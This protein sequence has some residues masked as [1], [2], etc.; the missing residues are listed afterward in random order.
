[1]SRFTSLTA[2]L[3][4]NLQPS[5]FSYIY[6]YPLKGHYAP[7]SHSQAIDAWKDFSGPLNLYVHIPFCSSKCAFC[8]LF[9]V[10]TF[11]S[12]LSSCG[13]ISVMDSKE[14]DRYCAA[15]QREL[16]LSTSVMERSRIQS[17]HFGGGTPTLLPS[18]HLASLL[19]LFVSWFP[20]G[21]SHDAEI[22]I[23]SSPASLTENKLRELRSA[24]FTRLSLG[25]QSFDAQVESVTDCFFPFNSSSQE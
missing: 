12:S 4:A 5:L 20:T 2:R 18:K 17:L 24:G 1:M 22:A 14:A 19:D 7:L 9:T 8:N 16:T 15:L 10:T 3:R 11:S 25:V 6:T 23:E 21:L 13:D